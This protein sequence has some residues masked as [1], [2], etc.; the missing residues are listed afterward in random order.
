MRLTYFSTV[1]IHT[2]RIYTNEEIDTAT[3]SLINSKGDDAS[4]VLSSE[5]SGDNDRHVK[6]QEDTSDQ[7]LL[8]GANNMQRQNS[9][10]NIAAAATSESN[11]GQEDE[12]LD[13]LYKMVNE[14]NGGRAN[15]GSNTANILDEA[16]LFLHS[17]IEDL[18]D[19][20]ADNGL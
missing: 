16:T 11:D 13:I 9:S 4:D 8:P 12:C 6:Y 20:I 1:S 5:E 19:M 17:T 14:G 10:T 3:N 2:Q 18:D 15:D 7:V